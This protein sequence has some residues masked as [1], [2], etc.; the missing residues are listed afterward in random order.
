MPSASHFSSSKAKINAASQVPRLIAK[1][2]HGG[3]NMTIVILVPPWIACTIVLSILE[4]VRYM[5]KF[6]A[7]ALCFMTAIPAFADESPAKSIKMLAI[8]EPPLIKMQNDPPL[9]FA[10]LAALGVSKIR[11]SGM[12]DRL[13][14]E[15][16]RLNPTYAKLLGD[17]IRAA[18]IDA[19]F[20][21]TD[22]P[23]PVVNA[24]KPWKYKVENLNPEQ[25]TVLYT[26]FES[27]GI[28]SHHQT[29]YYQP[30]M[31]IRF[32]L[33]T[34]DSKNKC[35]ADDGIAF[36][37][38]HDEEDETTFIANKAE[39]WFDEDSAYSKSQEIDRAF[40]RGIQL[41]AARIAAMVQQALAP[42]PEKQK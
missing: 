17:G 40:Q 36:G 4:S 5:L 21:I 27:I 28:R 34:P 26:Y 31:Y 41:G 15:I 23:L 18:L 22:G 14:S 10:G 12:S 39:R 19:G 20:E 38:N 25:Q 30:A 35:A 9:I 1:E 7:V 8:H 37:D 2:Q 42:V 33:M 6:A 13:T 29:R 11:N 32:C 16:Y 3:A 24:E